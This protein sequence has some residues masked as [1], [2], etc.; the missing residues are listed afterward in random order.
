MT[1]SVFFSAAKRT[2]NGKI[3]GSFVLSDLITKFR[4]TANVF[5]KD[6]AIGFNQKTLQ[7]QKAFYINYALPVSMVVGDELDIPIYLFNNLDSN[8]QVNLNIESNDTSLAV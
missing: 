4:L 5:N 2:S 1:E 6:G 8:A 7:S 3:S